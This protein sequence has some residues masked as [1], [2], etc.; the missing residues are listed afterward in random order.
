M[1]TL[2]FSLL[3]LIVF[4][5]TV[6]IPALAQQQ[7]SGTQ[8]GT[9][10]P[11]SYLVTGSIQVPV[12]QTLTILPGTEFLHNGNHIWTIS[13]KLMAQGTETDSIRFVRQNP[14]VTQ[15]WGGIRF[16]TSASY[17]IIKY[18][19]IDN[20]QNTGIYTNGVNI[21][22]MNSRISNC[23]AQ[24]DGGGIHA[25]SANLTVENCVIVNNTA[26]NYNDGGGIYLNSCTE[27]MIRNSIIAHNK[28]TG[29]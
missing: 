10:G 12:N 20:C 4:S 17:S 16:Q 23:T 15:R 24:T 8:T 6:S 25:Y 5:L 14:I 3:M 9:L 27:V 11:G 7:I 28:A 2:K 19:I 22:V 29:T 13:G 21:S 1:N 26:A 18:C